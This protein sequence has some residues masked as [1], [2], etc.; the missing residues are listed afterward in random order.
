MSF[1]SPW[2]VK[3]LEDFLYYFCP[4]CEEK[5]HSRDDFLQHALNQHPISNEFLLQFKFIK[6]E[7]ENENNET[8]IKFMNNEVEDDLNIGVDFHDTFD[9]DVE[10]NNIKGPIIYFFDGRSPSRHKKILII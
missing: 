9:D 10:T 8:K 4:E 6:E 1:L 2:N 5:K 3:S 7:F